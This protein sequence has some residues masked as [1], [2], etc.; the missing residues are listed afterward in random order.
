MQE[1]YKREARHTSLQLVEVSSE[2]AFLSLSC[3]IIRRYF[4]NFSMYLLIW[5]CNAD[6]DILKTQELC[7]CLTQH[8][9]PNSRRKQGFENMNALSDL[10]STHCESLQELMPFITG[11]I[12]TEQLGK[13]KT[14]PLKAL[15]SL[16]LVHIK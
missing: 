4:L 11:I 5:Y 14:F 10:I 16:S 1:N 6:Q 8:Q 2:N 12:V 13:N 15:I 9:G 7:V 3:F